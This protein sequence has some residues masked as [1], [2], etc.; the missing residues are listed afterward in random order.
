MGVIEKVYDNSVYYEV[1]QHRACNSVYLYASAWE[2]NKEDVTVSPVVTVTSYHP[3][4]RISPLLPRFSQRGTHRAII[5][6]DRK[7]AITTPAN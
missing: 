7:T 1:N 5:V 6:P 4:C 3:T 2:F